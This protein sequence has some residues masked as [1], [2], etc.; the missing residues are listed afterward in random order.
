MN[1]NYKAKAVIDGFKV[2]TAYA[3][4]TLVAV[5]MKKSIPGGVL[6]CGNSIMK[7]PDAPLTSRNFTDKFGR[8]A[9]TLYYYE[10]KPVELW[11]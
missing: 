10:W 1:I 11:K 4:K 7:L 9:Y 8:G 3:G 5:P 2:G 6:S